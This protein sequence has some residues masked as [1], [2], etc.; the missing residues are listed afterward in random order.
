MDRSIHRS[1]FP[2]FPL[3]NLILLVILSSIV[4]KNTGDLESAAERYY[5]AVRKK[6]IESGQTKRIIEVFGKIIEVF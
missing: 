4:Q 3:F 1:I 6:V 5:I 2:G